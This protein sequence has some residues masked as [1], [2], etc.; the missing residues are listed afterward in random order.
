MLH[1][2]PIMRLYFHHLFINNIWHDKLSNW[3]SKFQNSSTT[4]RTQYFYF[5]SED[6]ALLFSLGVSLFT[7][8]IEADCLDL[9]TAF[10]LRLFLINAIP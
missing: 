7:L 6:D 5:A 4:L 2:T 10:S 3:I 8:E 9:C 1:S